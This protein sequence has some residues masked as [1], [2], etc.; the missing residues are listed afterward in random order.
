MVENTHCP[1]PAVDAPPG[2]TV[3]LFTDI[4]GSSGLQIDLG[5]DAYARLLAWHAEIFR[6][7]VNEVPGSRIIRDTGDGFF[8]SFT[9]PANAV[10]FAL[11][12]QLLMNRQSWAPKL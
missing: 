11:L 4:V 1:S 9:T 7:C 6:N 12:F 5:T 8:A 3:L 10:R 2:L